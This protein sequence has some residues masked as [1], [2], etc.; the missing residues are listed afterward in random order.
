MS[1]KE[2]KKKQKTGSLFIPVQLLLIFILC[3]YMAFLAYTTPYS[4]DDF[5]YITYPQDGF[6]QYVRNNVDHYII[7]NG[8]TYVHWL[9]ELD[10]Y[11]GR[12]IFPVVAVAVM[13]LIPFVFWKIVRLCVP[14][15]FSDERGRGG[16]RLLSFMI[17]FSGLFLAMPSFMKR[18]GVLWQSGFFNYV[19]PVVVWLWMLELLVRTESLQKPVVPLRAAG[20]FLVSFLTGASTEQYGIVAVC[21]AVYFLVRWLVLDRKLLLYGFLSTVGSTAGLLVI[22]LAPSMK[23]RMYRENV[24]SDTAANIMSVFSSQSELFQMHI[25]NQLLL[26]A[27]LLITCCLFFLKEKRELLTAGMILLFLFLSWIMYLIRDS[28]L[29]GAFLMI[30]LAVTGIRLLF[31]RSLRKALTGILCSSGFVASMMVLPSQ[32]TGSRLIVPMYLFLSL[33]LLLCTVDYPLIAGRAELGIFLIASLV[34]GAALPHYIHNYRVEM[35]NEAYLKEL[36]TTHELWYDVDYDREYTRDKIDR[37][38]IYLDGY[39]KRAR[40]NPETDRLYVYSRE[41]PG[42]LYRGKRVGWYAREIDGKWCLPIRYLIETAGGSVTWNSRDFSLDIRLNDVDFRYKDE[43]LR[44]TD[45][46]GTHQ[47]FVEDTNTDYEVAYFPKDVCE[48]AFGL[49]TQLTYELPEGK[50]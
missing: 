45:A 22:L 39:L 18:D 14:E 6:L 37:G 9:L 10:L 30:A 27:A 3:V 42:I 38:S 21:M 47:V 35:K 29:S 40:F 50:E 23:D 43:K 33:V 1:V 12:W 28:F 11:G 31:S 16:I 7:L 8:R 48:K 20:L 17:L 41:Y 34:I 13:L 36:K 4:I 15:E 26:T 49:K 19:L 32:S 5:R 24:F 2:K 46:E 25:W 44:W